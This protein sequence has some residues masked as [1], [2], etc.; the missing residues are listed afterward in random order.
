MKMGK[1]DFTEEVMGQRECRSIENAYQKHLT[2]SALQVHLKCSLSRSFRG[3]FQVH[4]K[5]TWSA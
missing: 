1:E 3:T 5:Y 4:L 2:S